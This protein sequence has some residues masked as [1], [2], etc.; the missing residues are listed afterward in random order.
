MIATGTI[1]NVITV[2]VGGTLGT[3]LGARLPERMRETIMHALGL[4][5]LV[6]GVQL[7]L[8]TGNILIVLGSLLL[9]GLLGELLGIERGIDQVG[10]WIEKR[11]GGGDR[12]AAEAPTPGSQGGATRF[13]HAFLTASLV[14]CVGPMTILGSIQD[15]LT[16]DY[17]LLAIKS[18]M[19]GFAALAFASTLGPGV[20]FSA[21]TVLLYQGGLTLG[22]G[23][24][25]AVLSDPMVAEMTATGGVLMLALGLGLLQV[26][27]I[28]AGNLL[29][30]IAIAPFIVAIVEWINR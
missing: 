9:G 10:H 18:T 2:L 3:L 23:W 15:G 26:K 1:I 14:F 22:A 8:E 29:P 19:D 25:D 5:T 7:S 20:I 4:L 27:K 28:R 24:A 17:T 13:S 6:I 16:G 21:L 12:P 11:A 30:A